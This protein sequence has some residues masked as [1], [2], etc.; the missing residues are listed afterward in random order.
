MAELDKLWAT[1]GGSPSWRATERAEPA[2]ARRGRQGRGGEAPGITI[3]GA[4]YHVETPQDAAAEVIRVNNAYPDIKGWAMVGGWA[5]FAKTLLTE[6]DPKKVKIVAVDALPTELP[7]VEKGVAPVL[8]AQSVVS[9]GQRRRHQDRRQGPRQEGR[10]RDRLDGS[11]AGHEGDLGAWARQ[12]RRGASRTSPR[13]TSSSSSGARSFVESAKSTACHPAVSFHNVSKRFPARGPS[14]TSASTSAGARATRCAARTARARARWA[15]CWPASSSRTRANHRRR[16]RGAVHEPAR[17]A[18][19]GHRRWCTRSWRSART[20]RSPRTCASAI[21]R[22]AAVR[23]ARRDGAARARCWPRRRADR[24]APPGRRADRRRAADGADRGGGRQRRARD[25][26]RRADEQPVAA[27]GRAP[28]RVAR[29][30]ARARRDVRLRLAPHAGDL[31]PLRHHHGAARR[32]PRRDRPTAS[33]TRRRW[34][35]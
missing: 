7:Y 31:P 17:R 1:R 22:G 35:S 10:P 13:N 14:R 18:G 34:C 3:V 4:F 9:V 11:R 20:C 12:L 29:A 2:P 30:A 16:A 8:L 5:L 32:T 21:C 33:S 15:S 24:R 23:V 26:L 19:G 28:L 6:L 27:R 25:H